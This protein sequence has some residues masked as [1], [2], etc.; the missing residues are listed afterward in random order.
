MV[1]VN[2][3]ADGIR[4]RGIIVKAKSIIV[5]GVKVHFKPVKH[6]VGGVA[7]FLIRH[8]VLTHDLITCICIA[9]HMLVHNVSGCAGND[10]GM[11][12]Q[13]VDF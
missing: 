8:N 7:N 11:R 3:Q 4:H 9:I 13:A 1:G 10:F 5:F 2:Y 6:D 12:I